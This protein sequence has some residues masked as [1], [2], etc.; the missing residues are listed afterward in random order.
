MSGILAALRTALVRDPGNLDALT[1]LMPL[2]TTGQDPGDPQDTRIAETAT[3]LPRPP[4]DH[5]DQP[6]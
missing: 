5:K 4:H 6:T 3:I 2:P 1:F